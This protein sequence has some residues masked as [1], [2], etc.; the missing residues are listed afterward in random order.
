PKDRG[1]KWSPD[2]KRIVYYSDRNGR[3]EIWSIDAQGSNLQQI[4]KTTGDTV[5]YPLWSPNGGRL[6]ASNPKNTYVFNVGSALPT[7]VAETLPS[8]EAGL[9][10]AAWSWSPD[11]N[12]LAG[13][14]WRDEEPTRGTWIY[15]LEEKK[16][17]KL[18]DVGAPFEGGSA[19]MPDSRTLLISERG[20]LVA[21]DRVTG[22]LKE[23]F[24][25][26]GY[27][28]RN[29]S[30]TADGK[31][32]FFNARRVEADIWMATID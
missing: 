16:Y 26:A 2:G 7:G 32:I 20:R 29:A 3:Y 13:F 15:S 24:R 18:S 8:I 4:T 9:S 25:P 22:Q 14:A 21:V 10:F 28:A 31:A 11:G 19:W 5:N 17:S 27:G 30:V 12:W 1:P 23:V 6:L